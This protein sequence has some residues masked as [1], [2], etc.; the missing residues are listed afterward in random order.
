MGMNATIQFRTTHAVKSRAQRYFKGAGLTLSSGLNMYLHALESAAQEDVYPVSKN[1]P[2]KAT[3]KALHATTARKGL[4]SFTSF[5]AF[6][7]HVEA[8]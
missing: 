6:K 5:D 2:N 7:K 8:I 1:I 4:I 3:A